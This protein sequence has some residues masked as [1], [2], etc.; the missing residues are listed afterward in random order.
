MFPES[1][2][3]EKAKK[4]QKG[5]R[6]YFNKPQDQNTSHNNNKTNTN[7]QTTKNPKKYAASEWVEEW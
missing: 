2:R 1:T 4:V 5:L 7:K 6:Q 3:G